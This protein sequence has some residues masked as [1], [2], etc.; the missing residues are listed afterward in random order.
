M[1]SRVSL[2]A[3][4]CLGRDEGAALLVGRAWVPAEEDRPSLACAVGIP[5]T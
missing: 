3:Q 2:T 5:S 1:A 4:E